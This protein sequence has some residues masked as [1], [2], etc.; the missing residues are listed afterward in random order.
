MVKMFR[1]K[2]VSDSLWCN[3]TYVYIR[4]NFSL[5]PKNC[6]RGLVSRK[7]NILI[8]ARLTSIEQCRTHITSSDLIVLALKSQEWST[9]LFSLYYYYIISIKDMRIWKYH[10]RG[11]S[12]ILKQTSSN[13]LNKIVCRSVWRICIW[14]FRL[15]ELRRDHTDYFVHIKSLFFLP[16]LLFREDRW[17]CIF[18]LQLMNCFQFKPLLCKFFNFTPRAKRDVKLPTRLCSR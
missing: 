11:N 2:Q 6:F 12:L 5:L 1:Y 14:I 8:L 4:A 15:K 16:G 18:N 13:S 7:S 3:T 10:F 17:R 9:L